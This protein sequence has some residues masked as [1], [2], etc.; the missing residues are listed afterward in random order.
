MPAPNS[1]TLN[2]GARSS[3]DR[4]F[5][6]QLGRFRLDPAVSGP[7]AGP[8]AVALAKSDSTSTPLA[9][10]SPV[11]PLSSFQPVYHPPPPS[12]SFSS[13]S[14]TKRPATTQLAHDL[15]QEETPLSSGSTIDASL[16]SDTRA[17]EKYPSTRPT[18]VAGLF[19]PDGQPY[20]AKRVSTACEF[21][22]K[23]KKKCDFRYPNCSACTRAGV[24]CTVLTLGQPVTSQAVPRDQIE[25][26]QK[27]VEW[28]EQLLRSRTGID[29]GE[30]TTGSPVPE[31][32]REDGDVEDEQPEPWYRVPDLMARPWASLPQ[33][34]KTQ[35]SETLPQLHS[36]ALSVSH[37]V[38]NSG[39]HPSV[40]NAPLLDG[41]SLPNIGELFRDK[42]ENRP[43]S[44]ARPGPS[45]ASSPPVRRLPSYEEA[46]KLA[47]EYFDGL[48]LQ[49]PFL[50]RVEFIRDLGRIYRGDPVPAEVVNCYHITM[51]TA[52]VTRSTSD[53]TL[54]N[55]FYRASRD[56]L[57]QALQNEDLSALRA[58]LS[59]ALF[60]LSSPLGPS[61]WQILG[62]AM[63]LATS[64]GLH[65]PRPSGSGLA[66][67]EMAKRAFWSLYNMDRLVAVML[68]R[69]LGIADEDVTVD[70]PREYDDQWVE[71]PG[72]CLMS[73]PVQVIK[74]RRIFSR[75]YRFCKLEQ[76]LC[77][78][79]SQTMTN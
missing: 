21:C 23:R 1:N 35:S 15:V 54:A 5:R 19:A 8:A 60:A 27:R 47:H 38:S 42:L 62:T 65:K 32:E 20:K 7:A 22:R 55:S 39:S 13:S 72:T 69:P 3:S 43:R 56:T 4:G 73:I 29:V 24:Q 50:H 36:P 18:T 74:L 40:P 68:S 17:T 45:M 58:L 77:V 14:A 48:G 11:S 66:E 2:I 64:I 53:E 67:D 61:I 28:L 71:S 78:Q 26:L 12:Q 34:D 79:V 49:Y 57:G 10:S 51:A 75:I 31:G 30:L 63:R 44:I 33:R 41:E 9:A 70:L 59:L 46:E 25:T 52:I 37:S 76:L 16:T 6:G